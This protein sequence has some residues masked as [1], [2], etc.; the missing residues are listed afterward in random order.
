MGKN[1]TNV[2]VQKGD[3]NLFTERLKKARKQAGFSNQEDLAKKAN[4]SRGAISYYESGGRLP[5]IN[6]FINIADALNVSYDY[7]LGYSKSPIREYHDTKEITG[8]SDKAINVLNNL[9]KETKCKMGSPEL[10]INKIK[11]INYLLEQEENFDFLDKISDFLWSEYKT[12]YAEG[13][14]IVKTEDILGNTHLFSLTDL[15][16]LNILEIEILL[17]KLKEN[18]EAE[19]NV[20][21]NKKK[22]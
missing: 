9:V 7:L 21:D 8:L 2:I 15:K 19:N 6:F 16:N 10:A 11:T 3:I 20:Q 14:D 4:I 18:I 22:K 5:D 1:V 17:N 12:E 13:L